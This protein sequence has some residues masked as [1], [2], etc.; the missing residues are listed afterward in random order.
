MKKYLPLLIAFS[1][2]AQEGEVAMAKCSREPAE[3]PVDAD[4]YDDYY[5]D[6]EDGAPLPEDQDQAWKEPTVA[7]LQYYIPEAEEKEAEPVSE[8]RVGAA[9]KAMAKEQK[10][11]AINSAAK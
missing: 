7:P 5:G 1:L 10:Y 11:S 3:R 8:E 9:K 6:D 4:D 2:T